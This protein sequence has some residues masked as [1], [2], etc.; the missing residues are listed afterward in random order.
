MAAI[1]LSHAHADALLAGVLKTQI[2]EELDLPSDE[3]FVSSDP[4]AIREGD[5]RSKVLAALESAT[6]FVPLITPS[7]VRSTWVTFEYGQFWSRQ[8][9]ESIYPVAH[10][11]ADLSTNPLNMMQFNLV[12]EKHHLE[13]FFSLLHR[14]LS[15]GSAGKADL[16]AIIRAALKTPMITSADRQNQLTC[17]LHLITATNLETKKAIL[18]WMHDRDILQDAEL[19]W[20]G[21]LQDV[22]FTSANLQNTNLGENDLRGANFWGA[23]LENAILGSCQLQGADFSHAN[24]TGA[25][26]QGANLDAA[27]TLPNGDN[28]IPSLGLEQLLAH[29]AVV[30]R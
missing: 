15:R 5:W 24:L 14:A 8:Q 1:F 3:V 26:F 28:Y 29:K 25:S 21:D 27:T 6:V 10:P 7:S 30:D 2:M 23:N 17:K 18:R 12:T 19:K 22:D 4:D 20:I 16:D 11:K 9:G 13:V